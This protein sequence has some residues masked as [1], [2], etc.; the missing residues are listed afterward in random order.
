MVCFVSAIPARVFVED[1]DA[2]GKIFD[3]AT[4]ITLRY[5]TGWFEVQ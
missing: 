3:A 4:G 2:S 5:E 1:S